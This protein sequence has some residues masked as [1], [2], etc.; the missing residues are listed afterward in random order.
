MFCAAHLSC[1][2]LTPRICLAAPYSLQSGT[3]YYTCSGE[4]G[5]GRACA[6]LPA[7]RLPS[8]C[9]RCRSLRPC[10][11]MIPRP[12]ASRSHR[13]SQGPRQPLHRGQDACGSARGRL[14]Q[15]RDAEAVRAREAPAAAPA[16][17]SASPHGGQAHALS[18]RC[19]PAAVVRI[20]HSAGVNLKLS[21]SPDGWMHSLHAKAYSGV[22]AGCNSWRAN[23]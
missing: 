19:A 3:F 6:A 2:V 13:C 7:R 4:A 18:W 20:E 15:R 5:P 8:L 21:T 1:S 11:P 9:R 16:G 14:P 12:P 22:W 23:A 17:A 10:L